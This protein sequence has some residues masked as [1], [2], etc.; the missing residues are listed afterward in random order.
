MLLTFGDLTPSL[1][2]KAGQSSAI[3]LFKLIPPFAF[4]PVDACVSWTVSDSS[5]AAIDSLSGQLNIDE[6]APDGFNFIIIANV[7]NGRRILARSAWV[8]RPEAN[9]LVG[10]WTETRRFSCGS[11]R[12]LS[13][14]RPIAELAF[15]ADG[16]MSVTRI[17]IEVFRD[18][19]SRYSFDKE[20]GKVAFAVPA[21][22]GIVSD[23][24]GFGRFQI[25][26]GGKLILKNIT[27]GRFGSD[28]ITK[29]ERLACRY[30]FQ[31][32]GQ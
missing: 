13:P 10:V 23:V 17:P 15:R 1:Q 16:V 18:Y 8:Y 11:G 19:E 5:F 26:E 32:V 28:T 29:R 20:R 31:R 9:P 27:L 12:E 6:K 24:D 30:E 25:D 2:F 4:E 3:R 7:E 21:R 22:E 14:E